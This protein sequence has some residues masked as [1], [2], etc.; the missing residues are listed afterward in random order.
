MAI[1]IKIQTGIC[2]GLI[3]GKKEKKEERHVTFLNF[4]QY[5]NPIYFLLLRLHKGF[6]LYC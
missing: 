2:V 6:N 5:F 3:M 1:I 4:K